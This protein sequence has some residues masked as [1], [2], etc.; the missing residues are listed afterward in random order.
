MKKIV[1]NI[2]L[3]IIII[4]FIINIVYVI[5][6]YNTI[7]SI[8]DNSIVVSN[9]EKMHEE[10]LSIQENMSILKLMKSNYYNGRFGTINEISNIIIVSIILGVLVGSTI[11]MKEN[12]KIKYI[13]FFMVG[14]IFYNTIFSIITQGIYLKN[15]IKLS[16]FECYY[17][18]L[19]SNILNYV[20]IFI[21]I[22]VVVM[23]IK[24][25]SVKKLNKE[26]NNRIE[27]K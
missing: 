17:E 15:D 27:N 21:V 2:I 11:S 10:T 20:L 24:N 18:S 16:F 4:Y 14:N 5:Y 19:K 12:K 13:L 8:V 3:S 25:I 7:K 22:V 1:K 23:L 6:N 26:L 9:N